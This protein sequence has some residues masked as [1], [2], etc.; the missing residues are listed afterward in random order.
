M[1]LADSVNHHLV[2]DV[3]V[4]IFLSSGLDSSTI[5]A[6]ACQARLIPP[7]RVFAADWRSFTLSRW[8]AARALAELAPR[9]ADYPVSSA[10]RPTQVR[11]P[12]GKVYLCS[13]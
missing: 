4:G 6:L 9:L 2:A 7:D 3:P 10:L 13:E 11:T 12:T 1:A 8:Q 5:T